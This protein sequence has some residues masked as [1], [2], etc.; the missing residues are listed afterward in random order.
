[1]TKQIKSTESN[2]IR[3]THLRS[4]VSILPKNKSTIQHKIMRQL[5]EQNNMTLSHEYIHDIIS[6]IEVSKQY[7][8]DKTRQNNEI[9]TMEIM[10]NPILILLNYKVWL[11]IIQY[12]QCREISIII[13][14]LLSLSV[15]VGAG[16]LL[17]FHIYLG[18]TI[19][20][21]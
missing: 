7:H 6:N 5:K 9:E 10:E 19:R 16:L 13:M 3:D 1:M 12:I 14:M 11:L 17:S 21:H 8:D 15:F 4:S 18:I 2:I 20:F